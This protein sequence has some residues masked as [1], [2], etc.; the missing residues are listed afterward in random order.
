MRVS[1]TYLHIFKQSISNKPGMSVTVMLCLTLMWS[2]RMHLNSTYPSACTASLQLHNCCSC[3][4]IGRV[5]WPVS[6]LS[7]LEDWK[8]ENNVY[9]H[10]MPC[11]TCG[12]YVHVKLYQIVQMSWRLNTVYTIL[13]GMYACTSTC[14]HQK[15]CSF[16][17]VFKV[18][19]FL[20]LVASVRKCV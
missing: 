13:S 11:G 14:I 20:N 9:C 5:Q 19:F 15:Q 1:D 4:V 3:G 17:N 12:S 7:R 8:I 2:D 16:L 10:F 18:F 6:T